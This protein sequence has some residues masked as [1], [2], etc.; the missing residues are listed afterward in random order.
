M[1]AAGGATGEGEAP[2]DNVSPAV[3]ELQSA[4]PQLAI[5]MV[6]DM[7]KKIANLIPMLTMQAP[8]AVR[9][10]SSCFKG[11]D[12][13]LKELQQAQATLSAVGSPIKNSA[14]PTP[15][16]PGGTAPSLPNPANVNM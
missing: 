13:A 3:R 9:A 4:N 5:Q 2:Q 12:A 10:L 8:G 15:M 1:G 14:I 16:P 6:S 7:R 11:L